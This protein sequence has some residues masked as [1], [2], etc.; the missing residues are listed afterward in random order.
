MV[1]SGIILILHPVALLVL[2]S[3]LFVISF[4]VYTS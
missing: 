4:A 2:A 1:Y 3:I